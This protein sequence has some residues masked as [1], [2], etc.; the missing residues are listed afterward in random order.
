MPHVSIEG[1][2][3]GFQ[4][5][6]QASTERPT[7]NNSCF[8]T[9]FCYTL[10]AASH[11]PAINCWSLILSSL[12][13][14]C[15]TC[16]DVLVSRMVAFGS[17]GW[18]GAKKGMWEY[19]VIC[20]CYWKGDWQ[21]MVWDSFETNEIDNLR[22]LNFSIIQRKLALLISLFFISLWGLMYLIIF[23]LVD[24]VL[25]WAKPYKLYQSI[26]SSMWGTSPKIKD[27]FLVVALMVEGLR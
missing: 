14:V 25:V 8:F 11:A 9:C 15:L 1:R 4:V 5:F 21:W 26:N 19:G 22:R 10:F 17:H 18:N 20:D 23:I 6:L 3:Y 16:V 13:N 27:W 12:S 7:S 24:L 2:C